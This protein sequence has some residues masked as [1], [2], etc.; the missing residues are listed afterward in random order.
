[1]LETSLIKPG[2]FLT[3]EWRY[4]AMINYEI[5]PGLLINY[6]PRGTGLDDWKDKLKA[7]GKEWPLLKRW[8]RAGLS[9]LP[10]VYFTMRIMRRG[11]WRIGSSG[12]I[13]RY[14]SSIRG[15]SVMCGTA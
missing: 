8:F 6:R 5:D 4:L 13:L 2:R 10:H 11:E 7:G 3:A 15:V 14:L 9:L 1:M 12:I